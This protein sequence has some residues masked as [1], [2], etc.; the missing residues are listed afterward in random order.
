MEASHC[1]EPRA[2]PSRV[3][4][5]TLNYALTDREHAEEVERLKGQLSRLRTHM[6]RSEEEYT[7]QVLQADKKVE[8]LQA[9]HDDL[10]KQKERVEADMQSELE[11]VQQ[12]LHALQMRFTEAVQERD[13][14]EQRVIDMERELQQERHAA[15]RLQSVL[16]SFDDEKSAAVQAMV[17]KHERELHERDAAVQRAREQ[18]AAAEQE[19]E[20]LQ[21]Q[22]AE[23]QQQLAARHVEEGVM[24]SLKG[25]NERLK[26]HA[27]DLHGQAEAARA[28]ADALGIDKE[29]LKNAVTQYFTTDNKAMRAEVLRVIADVC[30]FNSEMKAK[31][32]LGGGS[33]AGGGRRG[34]FGMLTGSGSGQQQRRGGGDA[35]DDDGGGDGSLSHQFVNFLLRDVKQPP[36]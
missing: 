24:A 35:D 11:H 33:G 21:Q 15:K 9:A 36:V 34:L 17:N 19:K 30:E 13:H 22:L 14:V 25:E 16:A 29:I 12:Q 18:A 8:D 32:G 26:A 10:F 3:V 23:A 6:L 1:P 5:T 20:V 4:T 28:R 27:G 2:H 7:Q 31:A